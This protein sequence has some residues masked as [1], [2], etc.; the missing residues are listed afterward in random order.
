MK[1]IALIIAIAVVCV[2][3]LALPIKNQCA[4]RWIQICSPFTVR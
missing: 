3:L 4:H 1:E 2:F